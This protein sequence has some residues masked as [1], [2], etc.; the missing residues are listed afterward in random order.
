MIYDTQ[1]RAEEV[2]AMLN[3]DP[4][5]N[6]IKSEAINTKFGWTVVAGYTA[7]QR[8]G[9]WEVKSEQVTDLSPVACP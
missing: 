5:H 8:H 9:S 4:K 2:A 1:A 6:W 3:V 7:A